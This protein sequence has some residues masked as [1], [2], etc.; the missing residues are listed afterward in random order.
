MRRRDVLRAGIGATAAGIGLVFVKRL[1]AWAGDLELIKSG[2]LSAATEG[3]FPPFSIRKPNGDLDGLEMRMMQ[4]ITKRLGLTYKP[5]IIK[6]ESILI[7][8]L[9][10]EYDMS[11]NAMAITAERQKK[12]TFCDA[13]IESG[14]RL[15]VTKDSAIKTNADAKGK[16]VG[17]IVGSTYVKLAE[18]LGSEVKTYKSD[19]DAIQ[20]LMNGNI[21]A[22]ITDSIAAAYMITQNN[23]PLRMTDDYLDKAQDGWPVKQGKPNLVT[24]INKTMAA[25]VADGTYEKLTK[26][27]IGYNAFP[28]DPIRS[29][30]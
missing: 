27:L 10:G 7:G 17:V 5:V 9:A 16:R 1:P 20:D 19:P 24:A 23:L 28:K 21:D 8:L 11:S 12:V 26:P 22:V 4:E 3:T 18:G 6:W 2:E 14:A 15:I 29:Q 13:W 25:I 30:L